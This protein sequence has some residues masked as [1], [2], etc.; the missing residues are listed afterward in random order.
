[1]Q[2]FIQ[3]LNHQTQALQTHMSSGS[4]VGMTT[5]SR[6]VSLSSLH[7]GDGADHHDDVLVQELI[8]VKKELEEYRALAKKELKEAI[9][10]V[11]EERI[12]TKY[13]FKKKKNTLLVSSL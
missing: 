10:E 12:Q 8:S 13:L 11:R 9:S 5:A 3:D 7:S 6:D 1:M 4:D 2:Q